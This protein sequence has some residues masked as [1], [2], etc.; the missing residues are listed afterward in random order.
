MCAKEDLAKKYQILLKPKPPI[1]LE[2]SQLSCESSE[3]SSGMWRSGPPAQFRSPGCVYFRWEKIVFGQ[4]IFNWKQLAKTEFEFNMPWAI[5]PSPP[6][7]WW[8]LFKTLTISEI[9][10]KANLHV[11]YFSSPTQEVIRTCTSLAVLLFPSL[12]AVFC[13]NTGWLEHMRM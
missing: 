13:A 5:C 1:I 6:S 3:Q 12:S 2:V 10:T 7:C 9:H 8:P 11:C 4:P